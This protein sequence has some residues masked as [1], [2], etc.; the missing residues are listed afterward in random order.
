LGVVTSEPV[1]KVVIEEPW[2]V[3]GVGEFE[4]IRVIWME[5]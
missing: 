4:S 3:S 1:E 5:R 2:Q